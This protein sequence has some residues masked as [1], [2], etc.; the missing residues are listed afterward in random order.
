MVPLS[1]FSYPWELCNLGLLHYFQIL[2]SICEMVVC[3]CVRVCTHV[4]Q[5]VIISKYPT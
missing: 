3:V 4:S 5:T 1:F 2:L